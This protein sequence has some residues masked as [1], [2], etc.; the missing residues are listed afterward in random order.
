[1]EVC[2][3]FRYVWLF[4]FTRLALLAGLLLVPLSI[5]AEVAA[6]L[7]VEAPSVTVEAEGMYPG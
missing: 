4:C 3:G 1:M 7:R 2:G 5:G 6:E